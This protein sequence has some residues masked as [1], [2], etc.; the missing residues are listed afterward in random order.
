MV[1]KSKMVAN[2]KQTEISIKH[3]MIKLPIRYEQNDY[4][5]AHHPPCLHLWLFHQLTSCASKYKKKIK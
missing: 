3:K 2:D 5:P 1:A 4:R